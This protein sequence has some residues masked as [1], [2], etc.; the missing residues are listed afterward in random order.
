MLIANILHEQGKFLEAIDLYDQAIKLDQ[1]NLIAYY[2]KG[3]HDTNS[4]RYPNIISKN[5]KSQQTHVI[6]LSI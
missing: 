5:I 3:K 6:Q 1:K 4:K 2:G